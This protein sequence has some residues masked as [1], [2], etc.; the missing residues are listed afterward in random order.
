MLKDLICSFK[1]AKINNN[2]ACFSTFKGTIWLHGLKEDKVY[3]Y[4]FNNNKTGTISLNLGHEHI[5]ATAFLD[6]RVKIYGSRYLKDRTHLYENKSLLGITSAHFDSTRSKL[7]ATSLDCIVKTF[8]HQRNN[9]N[10]I[11]IMNFSPT[12]T[13]RHNCRVAALISIF[14]AKFH[15]DPNLVQKVITVGDTSKNICFYN[16][17]DGKA[18][19]RF[20]NKELISRTSAVIENHLKSRLDSNLIHNLF[21]VRNNKRM[22]LTLI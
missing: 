21:V 15:P 5:F 8:K 17:I 13:I 18:L 12:I 11:V 14:Q 4:K 6:K 7:A 1:C 16:S 9:N 3:I 19:F 22:I 2:L 10:K 20:A